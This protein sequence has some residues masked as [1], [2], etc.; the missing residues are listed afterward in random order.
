MRKNLLNKKFEVKNEY[1]NFAR[2]IRAYISDSEYFE[3][4]G[5]IVLAFESIVWAWAWFEIL[6]E[7]NILKEIKC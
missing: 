4:K 2:N 3:K 6:K 5:N 1:E 7:L